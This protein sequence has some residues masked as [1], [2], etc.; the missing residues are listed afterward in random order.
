MIER[1]AFH[2]TR[3]VVV[4]VGGGGGNAVDRMIHVGIPGVDYVACNTDR[5]ALARSEAGAKVQIGPA[6]THGMGAGGRLE[7]GQQAAEESRDDIAR[8]LQG[9]D[10]VFIT[11]G[12]GGG[13]GSG[14]APVVAEIA[15]QAGAVTVGVVTMP[16][17]FEGSRRQTN[18]Q[19]GLERLRAAVDTLIV[20]PNDRLL[21]LVN[22][23]VSLDLAFRIADDVLRQGV[24]GVAELVTRSGLINLSF[25][26]LRAIL[27]LRGG[28]FFSVGYGRGPERVDQAVR[29]A[30][31]HPLLDIDTLDAASGVLVHI[32]VGPQTTLSEVT[33]IVSQVTHSASPEAEIAFG[34]TIDPQMEPDSVQVIVVMTGVGGTPAPVA[35]PLSIA[36]PAIRTLPIPEVPPEL[37]REPRRE[38]VPVPSPPFLNGPPLPEP[39]Y[40]GPARVRDALDIPAFL[41]RRRRAAG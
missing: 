27:G 2:P 18:A 39:A 16:F 31:S 32:T 28:A 5:Q 8:V 1:E 10:M 40:E 38:L 26:N 29:T 25:A 37:P 34:A 22:A 15:R 3:I 17:T 11:S 35:A 7:V 20:V 30:L 33:Q 13:T 23:N 41:R 19:T 36:A 21:R 12:M 24:Q 14:A 9:S 4:G 6:C